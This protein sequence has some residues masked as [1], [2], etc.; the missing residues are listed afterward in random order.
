MNIARLLARAG[1]SSG[2]LPAVAVGARTVWT[3][4]QLA[5]R[6]ARIAGGMLA[7]GLA[8]GDRIALVMRNCADYVPLMFA[9]WWAGL[10]VVPVNAKLHPRELAY[11]IEHCGARLVLVTADIADLPGI[12]ARV[13]T[14]GSP[15]LEG[16]A[17][18]RPGSLRRARCRTML[19]GSSTPAAPPAGRRV[20][21]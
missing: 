14:V 9:G 4:R 11:I 8:P 3:Y 10:T 13:M 15:E 1:S 12:G 2:E 7:A 17:T 18:R 19:P 5:Q 20:P 21:C 16:L 6:T